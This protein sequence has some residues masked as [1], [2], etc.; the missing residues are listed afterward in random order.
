MPPAHELAAG[1][2]IVLGPGDVRTVHHIAHTG[3]DSYPLITI[4]FSD[5]HTLLVPA[6]R[7]FPR[8]HPPTPLAQ[9]QA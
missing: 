6:Q 4:T 1:D 2:V 8:L 7:A 9:Q 3:V 5:T